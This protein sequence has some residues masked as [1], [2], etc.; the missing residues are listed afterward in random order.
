VV[1]AHRGHRL[2]LLLKIGMLRWLAAEEPQLRVVD[3]DN[4]GSNNHMI[5][6]NDAIGYKVIGSKLEYQLTLS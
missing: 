6:V 1:R 4:A 3:T 5:A 2:G